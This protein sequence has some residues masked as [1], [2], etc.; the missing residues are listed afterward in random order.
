[1]EAGN[2]KSTGDDLVKEHQDAQGKTMSEVGMQIKM[3]K[4]AMAEESS[5]TKYCGWLLLGTVFAVLTMVGAILYLVRLK[6]IQEWHKEFVGSSVEIS[7]PCANDVAPDSIYDFY[8]LHC[9]KS[10]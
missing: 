4:Q 1:M 7:L 10:Y 6:N 8:P 9:C 2:E 3:M 5:K